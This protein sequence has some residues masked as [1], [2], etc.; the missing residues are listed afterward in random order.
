VFGGH[1]LDALDHLAQAALHL[2]ID[3]VDS[4][5]V[6]S[7]PT[8]LVIA[9][10]G[11]SLRDY[12]RTRMHPGDQEAREARSLAPGVRRL[13]LV[14]GAA[15]VA[16]SMVAMLAVGSALWLDEALSVEI[17]SLPLGDLRQALKIDGAPPAYYVLLHAWMSVFGEGD[18]A[19]R[20][21]SAVF[22]I[23]T[24]PLG[25]CAGH[26]IGGRG[27]AV[28]AVLLLGTSPYL[29]RY[30][31]ETRM[32]A[33]VI[34]LVV[35]GYLALW[36]AWERPS[37]YLRL[38]V[39]G[40]ICGLLVLTQ[41]WSLYLLIATGLALV[42]I[43]WRAR[44]DGRSSPAPR[45]LAAAVVGSGV[46]LAPWLPTFLY[47]RAHT[48]TPWGRPVQPFQAFVDT[49]TDFGGPGGI[50]KPQDTTLG[51]MLLLMVVVALFAVGVD[52]HRLEVDLRTRPAARPLAFVAGATLA[53]GVVLGRLS[54]VAFQ[55]RYAAVIFPLFVLLAVL[56]L[57][58][59]RSEPVRA[60]VLVV[61]VAMGLFG[62]G[63]NVVV[64][65]TQ[66][67]DLAGAINRD[68]VPGDVVVY[69]P[70]QLGPDTHRLIDD[71]LVDAGL[72]EVTYPDLEPPTRINWVR[73]GERNSLDP[74]AIGA[75]AERVVQMATPARAVWLVWNPT[76]RHLEGRCEQ[77]IDG[78]NQQR[79][80]LEQR[81]VLADTGLYENGYVYRWAPTLP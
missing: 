79:P 6:A 4:V 17:A 69:C 51:I 61:L 49:L 19:V 52:D 71:A 76:Y 31:S 1:D 68:A 75:L 44:V 9:L 23:A 81:I 16:A 50:T 3:H 66:A 47:Q 21:L 20:A 33:M 48:G 10:L 38:T 27:G 73:Y 74:V 12:T 56:G 8:A 67:A 53:I 54:G 32:Y 22:A 62:V 77:L 63:R 29:V 55:P 78:L 30:G 72:V 65:R 37:S 70:D 2:L 80:G 18:G 40:A 35:A 45:V 28:A 43:A 11:R 25:W 26:R 7:G 41:Y 46:F 59:L 36:R 60:G 64:D 57:A 24:L 14:A 13:L 34:F 58:Q 42:R 15:A 39:L 5:R